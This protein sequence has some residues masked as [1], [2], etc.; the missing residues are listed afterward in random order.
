MTTEHEVLLVTH[1]GRIMFVI[2][3]S[4]N[5]FIDFEHKQDNSPR[6]LYGSCRLLDYSMHGIRNLE[7][8]VCI[9]A[10]KRISDTCN[11]L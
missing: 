10:T 3:L 1:Y 11:A 7:S 8:G 6:H 4:I 2:L 5:S 9:S